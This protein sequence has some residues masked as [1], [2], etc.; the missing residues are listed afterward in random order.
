MA[1]VLLGEALIACDAPHYARERL[2]AAVG[3]CERL[4]DQRWTNRAK[5]GLGRALVMLDDPLGA[6]M[7]RDLRPTAIGNEQM[8]VL[9][10]ESLRKATILFD[11][12]QAATTAYGRP[13]SFFPPPAL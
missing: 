10:D 12:P 13:I 2:A 11:V 7:L 4:G 1:S 8:L 5:L 6:D 3:I 9:I